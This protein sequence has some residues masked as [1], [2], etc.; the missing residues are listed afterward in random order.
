MPKN[1]TIP[2]HSVEVKI[3]GEK[4]VFR[5]RIRRFFGFDFKQNRPSLHE[6]LMRLTPIW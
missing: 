3:K 2:P 5:F 6:M 1:T 4:P